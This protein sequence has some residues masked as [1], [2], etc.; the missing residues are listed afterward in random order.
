M[1]IDRLAPNQVLTRQARIN[2]GQFGFIDVVSLGEI[3]GDVS[4]ITLPTGQERTSGQLQAT[5]ITGAVMLASAPEVAILEAWRAA[6][7]V[8]SGYVV[9]GGSI[10]YYTED[11][12]PGPLVVVDEMF[13]H[14]L[15]YPSTDLSSTGDGGAQ[16]T[17]ALSIYNPR[18]LPGTV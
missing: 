11:G 13:V 14:G 8:G 17:F 12:S 1:P 7:E 18:L 4:K 5:D 15:T 16:L 6:A 10:Q 3:S 2:A 9:R